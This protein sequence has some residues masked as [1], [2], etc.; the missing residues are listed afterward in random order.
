MPRARS[1]MGGVNTVALAE[2]LDFLRSLPDGFA[3]LIYIDPPF[4][5]GKAQ[6]RRTPP[7]GPRRRR[8]PHWLP[9]RPLPHG[10]AR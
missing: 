6:R 5:T 8:R 3:N 2:S 10:R 9:G 1:L 4:N 7:D